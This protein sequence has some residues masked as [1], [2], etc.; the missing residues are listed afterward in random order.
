MKRSKGT[1][2]GT[3]KILRK[4]PSERGLIPINKALQEFE[5][6][7]KV[8]IKIEPSVHKAQP[9]R[10]F[11][12]AIGVVQGKQGKAFVVEVKEGGKKKKVITRSEHL[13]GIE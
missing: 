6:G 9:H 11:Q 8:R 1:R 2:Q 5:E 13:E 4:K 10:R 3:R 12:G 7:E